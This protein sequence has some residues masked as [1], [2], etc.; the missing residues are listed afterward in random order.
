MLEASDE[1]HRLN[2]GRSQFTSAQKCLLMIVQAG[3]IGHKGY[4]RNDREKI[5]VKKNKKVH[6]ILIKQELVPV[7]VHETEKKV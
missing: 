1:N 6:V 4:W 7:L 2:E 5:H 3:T